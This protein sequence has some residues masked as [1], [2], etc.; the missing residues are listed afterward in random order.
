MS[1]TQPLS[2]AAE[3]IRK[4]ECDYPHCDEQYEVGSTGSA[5][6]CSS[7]CVRR[8]T[9]LGIFKDIEHDR[10][11]CKSGFRQIRELHEKGRFM[12]SRKVRAKVWYVSHDHL[13]QPVYT[14][15]PGDP[16]AFFR[17]DENREGV[18]LQSTPTKHTVRG[19]GGR[20]SLSDP[21]EHNYQS[22]DDPTPS[23]VCKCGA[24]HHTTVL[25]PVRNLNQIMEA[26]KRLADVIEKLRKEGNHEQF[27]CRGTFLDEIRDRKTTTE[28]HT[29]DR[30]IFVDAIAEAL[31]FD[32]DHAAD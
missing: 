3:I 7:T 23:A 30:L 17:D 16:H 19:A 27:L 13:Q 12:R 11:F 26:A 1:A 31:Q 5:P 29:H 4:E 22:A 28:D 6:F 18:P 25:N 15:S 9:A 10:R 24:A 14:K 32:Y 8:S 20:L 2:D 21:S